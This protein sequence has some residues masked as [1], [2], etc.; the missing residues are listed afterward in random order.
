[1]AAKQYVN[2]SGL[3]KYDELIKQYIGTEDA[4]SIKSLSVS[5]NTV[6]FYKTEDASGTAAYTINIPDVSG[7]MSK[8]AS[9]TGG[10]I[11]TSVAG[12]EVTE[13]ATA[14]SDL[15]TNAFVGAIPEGATA[16]TVTGYAKEVADSKDSAIAT[17]QSAAE[18]AQSDV[19]A[20]ETYVGEIPSGAT[21]TDVV[22]YAAEVAGDVAS[23]LT[24]LENS[25]ADV[26]TSGAAEDVSIAD[27]AGYFTAT[28][29]EGAL[30]ELA[31]A[32]SGGVASK[33]VYLQDESA[34]Q[35]DYAKVY[36]LYQGANAPDAETDPATLIGSIN[37]PKDKVVQDGHLVTVEDGV[38]SDGDTVPAGTADGTYV[39]LILQNVTAP[40]YINVQDLID[41]Y[42]G[43]TTAEATVAISATNEITVT[44]NEISG[45]K[46]SAGSVA[47][48][49]L[50]QTVQGSLDLADSAVQSV[51]EGATNGTVAVD[52]T[53]VAVHGLGS[54]AYTASTAYDVAGAASDVQDA[55]TGEST[56]TSTDLTLYGLR[57]YADGATEAVPNSSIEGLFS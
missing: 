45:S 18:A 42:T 24:T 41:V 28:D 20:L 37:V 26:A 11:V 25:L 21:A 33:T 10:K 40:I 35:S 19:D 50:D 46:L 7:F 4:K 57:A 13:S 55:V 5:G 36:K 15:A 12:G 51:A 54:A 32:S 1:M 43:G 52:G 53:D 44:I 6:S 3:S 14:I 31:Q 2:F 27:S 17:A 23:D 8:I 16:T 22:G 29:V 38:D 34:G 9:A 39:K 47:K 56:D 49:K 48:A 30:A